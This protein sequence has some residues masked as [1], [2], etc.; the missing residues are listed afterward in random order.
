VRL[1]GLLGAAAVLLDLGFAD[2]ARWRGVLRPLQAASAAVLA[3]DL[4]A[5]LAR[6]E[7]RWPGRGTEPPVGPHRRRPRLVLRR[8]WME[9]LHLALC[10]ALLVALVRVP[11][12]AHLAPHAVQAFLAGAVLLRLLKGEI[13]ILAVGVAPEL[14]LIGSFVL[15]VLG[16]TFL[17]L[18]PRAVQPGVAPLEP[19]EALF[20][21]VSACTVTGLTVRETGATFSDLGS[22][23]IIALVQCGALGLITFVALASVASGR[24]FSVPQMVTLKTLFGVRKGT[25]IRP[26]LVAVLTLTLGVEVVGALLLYH[27][28][29][30]PEG[31]VGWSVFH[32]ISAFCNA[33][34]D[35][36]WGAGPGGEA[37]GMLDLHPGAVVV[38]LGLVLV[39]GLGFPVLRELCP[40]PGVRPRLVPSPAHHEGLS[41]HSRLA[42]VSMAVLVLGG[43]LGLVLLEWGH[44]LEGEGWVGRILGPL[45][46]SITTRTAGFEALPS[47]EL[48]QPGRVLVEGLMV[49]GAGPV[50]TGGGV[51]TI[52][53]AVLLLAL[54]RRLR[55]RPGT[56]AF[57]RPVRRSVVRAAGILLAS[58]LLVAWALV[59]LLGLT[60]PAISLED[61]TFE[62]LSALST[63]GLS[64]AVAERAEPGGQLL[65]CLAMFLG[66]VGP[67][68]LVLMLS[69]SGEERD[70]P[71]GDAIPIA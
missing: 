21:A 31:G 69:R 22:G 64:A 28:V 10:T 57:G 70:V 27:L 36:G 63:V 6:L 3:L 4:V 8:R 33:G 59:L 5:A 54:A 56:R 20:T 62:V 25:D 32:S 61:R 44:A 34:F 51:K 19:I 52:A 49:I 60:D 39:G 42:L 41:L 55:G 30:G 47:Q 26:F 29:P 14:L 16:G 1:I 68:T 7:P 53:V 37:L 15:L 48:S 9:F 35:L 12:Q 23:M 11:G 45:A 17:L 24:L 58:Y 66:R 50:S 67:L 18:L 43:W 46:Q 2:A 13:R 40:I 71:V 65:L 38:L